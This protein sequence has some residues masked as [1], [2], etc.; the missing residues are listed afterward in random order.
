MAAIDR[1]V[2]IT[3]AK[4]RLL[5]LTREVERDD[6][7]VAITRNGVPAGLHIPV[8]YPFPRRTRRSRWPVSVP[9]T[10]SPSSPER[11]ML[12]PQPAGFGL[13]LRQIAWMIEWNADQATEELVNVQREICRWRRVWPL[14]QTRTLLAF[15]A[16]QMS[17]QV[18]AMS[19]LVPAADAP[20]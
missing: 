10:C 2:P 14:E 3:L 20:R 1:F 12:H 7:M 9:A 8:I 18:L 15:R 17:D 6:D 19:G 13:R 4:N 5:D 16:K 11:A